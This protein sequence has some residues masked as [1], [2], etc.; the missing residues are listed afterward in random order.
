M[1]ELLVT[2]F[3][4]LEDGQL[5]FLVSMGTITLNAIL[6]WFFVSKFYLGAQ[7]LV[8]CNVLL[9]SSEIGI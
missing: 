4:A 9:S 6:D 7:G 2:V 3:Y 1:R 5:P 8:S